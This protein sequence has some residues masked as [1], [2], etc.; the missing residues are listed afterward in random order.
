MKLIIS[1][2]FLISSQILLAQNDNKIIGNWITNDGMRKIKVYTKNNKYH[3]VIYWVKNSNNQK[4][5]GEI[6][7]KNLE[8]VGKEFEN[9]TFKM[10]SEE[11]NANCS[12][13]F[14]NN[15]KLKFTIYHGLKI[16]GHNIYLTK[17]D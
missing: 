15:I 11:H 4:E 10:P 12:A 2:I 13:I 5:I 9:G 1:I 16:F 6:I 17:I 3:G 8:L 7:F 14:L